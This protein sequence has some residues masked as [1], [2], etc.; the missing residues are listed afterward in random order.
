V[1]K[2]LFH[3]GELEKKKDKIKALKKVKPARAKDD[4][5]T[6]EA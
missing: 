1:V 3:T 4:D 2:Y 5:E 6:E